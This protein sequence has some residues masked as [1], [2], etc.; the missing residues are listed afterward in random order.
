M[1][2]HKRIF[3]IEI[4]SWTVVG[5]RLSVSILTSKK[6]ILTQKNISN[7]LIVMEGGGSRARYTGFHI[8]ISDLQIVMDGGIDRYI[9]SHHKTNM[10]TQKDFSDWDIVMDGGGSEG[11]LFLYSPL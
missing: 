7:W 6:H 8:N 2:L 10:L 9:D 3:Q 1:Y 11:S 5:V 4:L